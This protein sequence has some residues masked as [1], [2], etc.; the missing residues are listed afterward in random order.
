MSGAILE[1]EDVQGQERVTDAADVVIIGTGAA[2]ATAARVLTERG[3]DVV[4]VEEGRRMPDTGFRRDALSAFKGMWRDL[5]F[6]VAEGRGFI[7]VLQGCAVGGTTVMNGAIIHRLPEKIHAAWRDDGAID[8]RLSLDALRSVYERMD[9]ELG[10]GPAPDEVF[11]RNNALMQAGVEGIGA[12]GNRIQRNVRGCRGSARCSQGC[13][14]GQKQSMHLTYVPRS[15]ERGARV[16]A[17]CRAERVEAKGGRAVGVHAH[18]RDP[19]TGDLGPHLWVEARRAVVVAASAVQTPLLLM[20]SGIGRRSG[21]VGRRFQGHPGTSVMG[22]F[23]EPVDMWF[24][25]TQGYETTHFWDRRMKFESV[26]VPFEIGLARLPGYGPELVRRVA[27]FGHVAQWGVQVRCET[28][29][30]VRRGLGGGPK[31]TYSMKAAD[32]RRFKEGVGHLIEMMFAAGAR[33]VY[34]G[35]HGLPERI[36]SVDEAAALPDLPDDPRR[37][38]FIMAHLFGTATMHPDPR[39]GVVGADGQAHEMPGLFVLDS[40][41]F[42]TNL[43]VNPQHTIGAFAWLFSEFLG[44]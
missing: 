26:G 10:V 38:H 8:D 7:P 3:L 29:G 15:V 5:G 43:G 1:L 28:H 20:A 19:L 35:V 17:T 2:G 39:R 14:T 27:G 33:E 37:F 16:Y 24:G 11:G 41:I 31:I 21:L 40:S 36:T 6:Q 4:M 9:E 30:R 44:G 12:T 13:P 23:D 18:F 32:V 22:V 25:A 42:P 34:P